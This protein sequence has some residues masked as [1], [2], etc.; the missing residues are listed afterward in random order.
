M[1]S[2][3]LEM[4]MSVDG[5]VADRNN[6]LGDQDGGR[7]HSWAAADARS[8]PAEQFRSRGNAA[9]AVRAGRRTAAYGGRRMFEVMPAGIDLE[10][11]RAVGT[12]LATHLRYCVRR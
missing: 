4:S 5:Y 9:G 1:S 3:V 6:F 2:S 8:R 10:V 7:L 12:P 11:V